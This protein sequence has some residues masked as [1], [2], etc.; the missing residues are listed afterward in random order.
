MIVLQ[1]MYFY[2]IIIFSMY[3]KYFLLFFDFNCCYR[4]IS[5]FCSIFVEK[6]ICFSHLLIRWSY[7][8]CSFWHR[9]CIVLISQWLMFSLFKFQILPRPG[10]PEIPLYLYFKTPT[11]VYLKLIILLV[12]YCCITNY[13]KCSSLK[14]PFICSQFCRSEVHVRWTTLSAQGSQ[15]WNC[16]AGR[17]HSHLEHRV[18]F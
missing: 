13:H 2:L 7:L 12:F 11:C 9:S 5:Y 8:L 10:F 3:G 4:K 18:L 1:G 16:Y 14:H 6:K 17:M 15:G